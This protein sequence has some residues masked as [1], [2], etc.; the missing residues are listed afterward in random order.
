[1]KICSIINEFNPTKIQ[2]KTNTSAIPK[3]IH[4][5]QNLFVLLPHVFH[6]SQTRKT[7]KPKAARFAVFGGEI[8]QL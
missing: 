6:L 1:V 3:Q 8:G 2:K 7:Q 4:I 5:T